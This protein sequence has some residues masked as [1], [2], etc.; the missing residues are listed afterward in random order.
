[1]YWEV[2]GIAPPFLTSALDEG[3]CSTLRLS[4]FTPVPTIDKRPGL[5][6]LII[7]IIIIIISKTIISNFITLLLSFDDWTN[8]LFLFW[9][10]ILC[11]LYS[12]LFSYRIKLFMFIY[13]LSED[14]NTKSALSHVLDNRPSVHVFYIGARGSVVG[15]GT[16][17]QAGKSPFRVPMR[18]L[19]IFNWPNPSM[20]VD[21]ASNR[22][23]YQESSWG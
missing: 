6:N 20:G 14:M 1:V 10:K 22:N 4:R 15:G 12:H 9:L 8:E 5:H 7:I 17:L 18:S 16:M 23:E 2:E 13:A 19:N 3:E 11:S 21:S